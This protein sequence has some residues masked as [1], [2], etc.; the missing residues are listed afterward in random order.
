MEVQLR[1]TELSI[2]VGC[3]SVKLWFSIRLDQT[4]EVFIHLSQK[5]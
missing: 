2:K 3:Q 5:D 1:M 4:R